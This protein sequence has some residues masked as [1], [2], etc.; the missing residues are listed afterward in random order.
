MFVEL[1]IGL[2]PVSAGAHQLD[3]PL[4]LEEGFLQKLLEEQVFT[5]A[6][7]EARIW[8]DG[9]DCNYLT[10]S[11][12]VVRLEQGNIHTRTAAKM[13]IGKSVLGH[14]LSIIKWNGFIE[15]FQEPM[16]VRLNDIVE[17]RIADSRIYS[18]EDASREVIGTLW[19]WCKNYV[20]PRFSRLRLDLT[21]LMT[22]LRELLRL[23]FTHEAPGIDRLL[24]SV[25]INHAVITD[26]RIQLFIRMELQEPALVPVQTPAV[27][28]EPTFTPEEIAH[29]EGLWQNWDAFLTRIIKQAGT[30]TG[31]AQLHASLFAVLLNARQDLLTVLE[32]PYQGAPDPVPELFSR[33][34][35]ALVPELRKVSAAMPLSTTMN[36][37]S[38]IT[39]G[40][41][42][43]AIQ[44]IGRQSGFVL[45]AD[46]LRRMVRM[47]LPAES[48]NPLQYDNAVDRPLRAIFGYGDPIPLPGEFTAWSTISLHPGAGP[49]AGLMLLPGL[50]VPGSDYQSLV[51]RLNGWVPSNE[52]INEYLL[53][54]QR[55]LEQVIQTRLGEKKLAPDLN[56]LFRNLVLSTAWQESCWRQFVEERGEI[57][58]IGSHAG[59]IGIMQIN[60]HVWRGFYDVN[61]L[62]HDVGYNARA[63]TEILHH[64]LTDYAIAK[65]EH[66]L[67]GGNDN[68]PRATYAMYNGGPRQMTRYREAKTPRTL[69]LIDEAFWRK[70]QTVNDGNIMG[71]AECY[72]N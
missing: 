15:V 53:T 10:L 28:T 19:R 72:S 4:Q 71:V 54:V 47:L 30:D 50:V 38:F 52:V 5:D 32:P 44:E 61:S 1:L 35:H 58:P 16:P 27:E 3:V 7:R 63:G 39:A 43:T 20:H 26:N 6:N 67:S 65:G 36:Y 70:Y 41:A 40:D 14:C 34:W 37:L 8:S 57:I 69:R 23:V 55:L 62:K 31:N 59:A 18:H 33:S 22:E 64:Y 45:G 17:F 60:Q 66:E 68:L 42:L 29:W 25:A 11:A 9:M 2:M 21:P 46:A 48:G 12:P 13:K 56:G 51:Q 24:G 49:L